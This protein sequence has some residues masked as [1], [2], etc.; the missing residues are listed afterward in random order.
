MTFFLFPFILFLGVLNVAY[1]CDGRG[2]GQGERG[3]WREEG[4]RSLGKMSKSG[5]KKVIIAMIIIPMMI[6]KKGR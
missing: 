3:V 2:E 6:K 4:R 5:D 1:Y